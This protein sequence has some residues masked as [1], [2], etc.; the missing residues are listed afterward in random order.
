MG[1][2]EKGIETKKQGAV[3]FSVELVLV[4]LERFC[5]LLLFKEVYNN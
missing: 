4:T 1:V 3:Y 2:T 5:W